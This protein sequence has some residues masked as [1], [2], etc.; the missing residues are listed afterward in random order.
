MSFAPASKRGLVA[1]ASASGRA[2]T[3]G[4]QKQP[5]THRVAQVGQQQLRVEREGVDGRRLLL[6]FLL[7]LRLRVHG[8]VADRGR[9]SW[10]GLRPSRRGSRRPPRLPRR[11]QGP[12]G[13]G[14]V[15]VSGT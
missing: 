11:R 1:S 6:L 3:S 8:L 10:S 13:G 2:T 15:H 5:K 7:L 12:A 4:R 14:R 9:S